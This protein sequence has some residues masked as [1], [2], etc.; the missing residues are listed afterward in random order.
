M[1]QKTPKSS[2]TRPRRVRKFG[3][4]DLQGNPCARSAAQP[5]LRDTGRAERTTRSEFRGRSRRHPSRRLNARGR[6]TPKL[7]LRVGYSL[8]LP[9]W[10]VGT[11][12][13]LRF[14]D[15][16]QR[17]LRSSVARGGDP[18]SDDR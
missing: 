12:L 3:H 16:S 15:H 2:S 6:S 4:A 10:R 9:A 13:S 14:V 18:P 8:R 5:T 1:R 11:S 7:L 17:R